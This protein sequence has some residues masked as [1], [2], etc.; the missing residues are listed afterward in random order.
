MNGNRSINVD[1]GKEKNG[2]Y[3][4]L[5]RE[6]SHFDGIHAEQKSVVFLHGVTARCAVRRAPEMGNQRF[7]ANSNRAQ[8]N[9]LAILPLAAIGRLDVQSNRECFQQTSHFAM[10]S[11]SPKWEA[12]VVTWCKREK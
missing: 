8:P 11:S 10:G 1:L 5:A 9:A 12:E 6:R 3:C 2:M 4:T 7:E